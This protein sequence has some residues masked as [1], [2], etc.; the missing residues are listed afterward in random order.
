M[1]NF[2]NHEKLKNIITLLIIL[3][4][5]CSYGQIENHNKKKN[6]FVEFSIIT[7]HFEGLE[8]INDLKSDVNLNTSTPGYLVLVKNTEKIRKIPTSKFKWLKAVFKSFGFKHKAEELFE[9]EVLIKTNS[10]NFWLPIQI[11]LEDFWKDELKE[12]EYALI[13]I[14]AYGTTND[15]QLNNK[16]LFTINSFNSDYYDGLW[17]ETLNSFNANDSTNGLNC[18]NKLI[19]L[20]PKDGQNYSIIGFYYYDKGYPTNKEL[21]RKSDALYDKAIELT[22]SYSYVYYQKALVKMQMKEYKNAWKNIDKARKLG[23][24]NI[25]QKKIKELENKLTYSE[26]LK[27]TN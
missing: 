12:N 1:F 6:T 23:E 24:T 20:N 5:S 26:Y 11:S 25:E 4:S 13:Y 8:N 2:E 18:I 22:P 3:T 27:S 17:E 7:N 21:L 9:N 10:G 15:T 14:R 19:E 16:W